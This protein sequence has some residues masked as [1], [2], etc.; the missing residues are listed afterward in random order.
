[1][2]EKAK[3]YRYEF[4]GEPYKLFQNVEEVE[5]QAVNDEEA[6]F[7]VLDPEDMDV[8]ENLQTLNNTEEALEIEVLNDVYYEDENVN[9]NKEQ[10]PHEKTRYLL[11]RQYKAGVDKYVLRYENPPSTAEDSVFD[12]PDAND[13]FLDADP[14]YFSELNEKNEEI[15]AN[16]ELEEHDTLNSGKL[17]A[18]NSQ[19]LT[20]SNFQELTASNSDD[21]IASNSKE[22][23]VSN[24]GAELEQG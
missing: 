9:V 7:P 8:L 1:M 19:E 6:E 2:A 15:A 10:I 3:S 18:S 21:L 17:S 20:A 22:L 5:V 11:P 4:E 24:D 13:L 16:Y 23:N 14:L 12:I